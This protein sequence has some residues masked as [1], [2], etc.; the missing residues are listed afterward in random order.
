[1]YLGLVE[2]SLP[3]TDSVPSV[4]R[5]ISCFNKHIYRRHFRQSVVSKC[6]VS[7]SRK[8]PRVV[9]VHAVPMYRRPEGQTCESS[10]D[11]GITRRA[12]PGRNAEETKMSKTGRKKQTVKSI[13]NQGATRKP[14]PRKG[15]RRRPAEDAPAKNGQ[16]EAPKKARGRAAKRPA[17]CNLAGAVKE[18]TH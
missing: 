2:E 5:A 15:S 18:A 6:L 3:Q 9:E 11:E 13:S 12:R 16:R 14:G 8:V 10:Q 1:M 17:Y 7:E 4:D